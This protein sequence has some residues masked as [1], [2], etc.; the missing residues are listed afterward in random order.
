MDTA[1]VVD[2]ILGH[3][4]EN[5]SGAIKFFLD[6]SSLSIQWV[7]WDYSLCS[8]EMLVTGECVPFFDQEGI[9]FTAGYALMLLFFLPMALMDL[10]VCNG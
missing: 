2:T 8:Q 3:W 5:G 6:D 4:L 1:Q 10:K 7:N 9:L